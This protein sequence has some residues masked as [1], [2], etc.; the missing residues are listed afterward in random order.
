MLYGHRSART[1]PKAAPRL[2]AREGLV[3]QKALPTQGGLLAVANLCECP[4]VPRRWS[5]SL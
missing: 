1:I 2:V 3:P 5:P 4:R